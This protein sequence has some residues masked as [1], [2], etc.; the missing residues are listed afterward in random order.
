MNR[1]DRITAILIQLQSKRIVKAQDLADR[2][3]ISL[4]TV[5]RDIRTLEEAGVPLYGEAGV[6]YS[7]VDGYRLPPVMFTREEAMAFLTAEKLMEKF[8]DAALGEHFASAMFKVKAVLRGT[9]KDLLEN[10]DGTIIVN[11][12]K[13]DKSPP[14]NV[15]DVLLKGVAEKMA[16]KLVY[17]AFGNEENSE[18]II[19]PIGIFHEYENWYTVAWCH[20]R[21][22]YRQFRADRIVSVQLTTLPHS[23][24]TS[25]SAYYDLH[26]KQRAT[27]TLQ[28][29]VIRVEKTVA[30]Y[31]QESRHRY[32]F[33]SEKI[34][35]DYV[36][37]TFLSQHIED[38]LARWFMMF[39]DYGE[40]VEPES[41]KLRVADLLEK[42]L[43]KNSVSKN[44]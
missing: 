19:E 20:L 11:N 31:M 4:R 40:I 21:S 6:G 42:M 29:G 38:G 14:I 34:D 5:Y 26:E 1:F 10:L 23:Q 27:L 37:M 28:K 35:G 36:E 3:G 22:E 7:L 9:E 17:R 39:A 18:R 16:V 2:F 41:L 33:V 15:L 13:R 24:D 32:G 43:Q 25:L 44:L 8:T 12:I 30:F